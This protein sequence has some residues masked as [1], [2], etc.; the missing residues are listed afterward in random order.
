MD[1]CAVFPGTAIGLPN[2]LKIGNAQLSIHEVC[3]SR[4]ICSLPGSSQP[5][6]VQGSDGNLYV[7]KFTG[8]M[9]DSGLALRESIGSELYLASGLMT[10]A[11]T[12]LRLT[13]SFLEQ[14][15]DCWPQTANGRVRPAA[16]LCFAS[17]FLGG[18]GKRLLEV[19]PGSS[20]QRV[21]NRL[22]FWLAWAI[23]ICAMHAD[24][25]QAIFIEQPSRWLRPVFID[26]GHLF[27]G[28]D[29]K[30]KLRVIASR[31]LDPRIYPE[32][33]AREIWQLNQRIS[34][35]PIDG[36][37]QK[38]QSLPEEWRTPS[39]LYCLG[40]CLHLLASHHHVTSVLEEI[41]EKAL[42]STGNAPR[43]D[44]SFFFPPVPETGL[45]LTAGIL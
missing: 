35:I 42:S 26:H 16:G 23:D 9:Q 22:S 41:T 40:Q 44:S 14:N 33:S 1:D 15:P 27:G 37:W 25:R 13:E 45:T 32:V 34:A 20:F 2:F 12:P 19:L 17:R 24:N 21:R 38:A 3:T 39:V 31:Y 7:A 11:W 36:I 43:L 10:P 4:F 28:P 18:S 8:G 6:L 30:Q 29:N 5:I